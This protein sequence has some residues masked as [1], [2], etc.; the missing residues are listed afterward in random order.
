[1]S[2]LD[3]S[4]IIPTYNNRAILGETLKRI[5]DQDFEKD[6]Y[7]VIV[8]DD[9]SNDGT[10]NQ[11]KGLKPQG[12][13][14]YISHP[15][16]LG[17]AKARNS[18]I[19]QARGGII[20]MIDEDIW[21]EKDFLREHYRAHSSFNE[22]IVVTGAS[23]AAVDIPNSFWNRYLCSRYSNILK[24][25]REKADNLT[26]GYFRTGNVS[27]KKEVLDKVGLFDEKFTAYGGEDTDLGYRIKK[28]GF[29]IVYKDIIGQHYF[30]ATLSSILGKAYQKGRSVCFLVR[31]YPEL[32][33]DMQFHSV[34]YKDAPLWK[35]IL[36]FLLYSRPA[37]RL[38]RSLVCF[39][40]GLKI[41]PGY[42]LGILEWQ[43][44]VQG[45]REYGKDLWA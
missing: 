11:L 2:E 37:V 42:L 38:N 12:R 20:V 43:S 36:K 32:Y 1:M 18:G 8:V 39:L 4:I 28:E 10:P 25:M 44:Y 13:F 30:D 24:R 19:K 14:Q 29:R 6:R 21:V 15:K 16:N 9:G 26:Y 3:F 35:N 45:V 34:F 23:P 22:N 33:K 27:L 17:R 7:E 31:K 40:S 5:F 41:D